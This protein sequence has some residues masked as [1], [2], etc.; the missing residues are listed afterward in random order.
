VYEL[1]ERENNNQMRHKNQEVRHKSTSRMI[2]RNSTSL[3]F[4]KY[5]LSDEIKEDE[6]GGARDTDGGDKKNAHFLRKTLAAEATWEA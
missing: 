1:H 3:L 4:T 2:Q 5:Y 6:M